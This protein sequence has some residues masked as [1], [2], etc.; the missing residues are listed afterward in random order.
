L[1]R[2]AEG[3]VRLAEGWARRAEGWVRRAEGWA[4]LA[5]GWARLAEGLVR[6]ALVVKDLQH[7]RRNSGAGVGACQGVHTLP[8]Q[9]QGCCH[10]P[11]LPFARAATHLGC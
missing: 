9:Q 3:L 5:E 4:R 11:P 1:A 6:R 8:R 10:Q 7:K 2:L